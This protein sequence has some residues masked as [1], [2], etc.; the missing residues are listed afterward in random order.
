VVSF[1]PWPLYSQGKSSWYPLDRRLGGPQSRS[2]RGGLEKIPSPAPPRIGP[3]YPEKRL[4]RN[5]GDR[6]PKT[7]PS[8]K[9]KI[10]D[11]VSA[12]SVGKQFPD[13]SSEAFTAMFQVEVFRVV[14]P[15]SVAVGYR[16]FRGPRCLR[17]I[18]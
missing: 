2:G 7:T 6:A 13:L 5:E 11:S 4:H 17:L 10:R 12:Y 16:R 9:K 18:I 15:C 1:T 8:V 14:I 3:H